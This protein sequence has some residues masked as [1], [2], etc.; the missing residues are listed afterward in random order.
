VTRQNTDL[1][2]AILFLVGFVFGGT[3]IEDCNGWRTAMLWS[4]DRF[5]RLDLQRAFEN[6]ALQGLLELTDQ[7]NQPFRSDQRMAF[8]TEQFRATLT[9]E[10]AE[11]F[12]NLRFTAK[13]GRLR[14]AVAA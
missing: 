5:T 14:V 10:G 7:R 6:L 1:E 8:F 2:G 4:A 9:T 3:H 12:H 13:G 11:Y